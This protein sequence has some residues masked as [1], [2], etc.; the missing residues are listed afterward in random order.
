[1]RLLTYDDA[2]AISF[3]KDLLESELA[4]YP[5]AILSH[6]WGPAEEE[7]TYNDVL[8]GIGTSKPGSGSA[9]IRFCVQQTRRDGLQYFWVDTYCIDKTNHTELSEAL[10]SMFR[11]YANAQRCYVCLSDVT[12]D[13]WE[14]HLRASKWFRRGWTLQ[15]LIAPSTLEFFSKEGQTIGTKAFLIDQIN[16]ITRIP[17]AALQGKALTDFTVHERRQWQEGRETLKPEDLVYSLLGL[18]DISMPVLYGEGKVKA[19]ERLETAL[20]EAQKGKQYTD[21]SLVFSLAEAAIETQRFVARNS[22]LLEI[23]THLSSDGSRRTVVLHGLGGIGKTQL[24]MA[25]AKRHKDD[26][27]AILWLNAKSIDSIKSS[28]G[29][30]AKQILREHPGATP[31]AGLDLQQDLDGVV[32]A[33]KAWL[34]TP[35]NA[36]WLLICDNYD[37]PKVP[38]NTDPNALELRH[39]LPEAYQGAVIVTT[40]SSEVKLGHCLRIKKLETLQDGL[41]ILEDASGR[42]EL[43]KDD[44]A[45]RLVL[46][47]DG[48]PLALATAGAYLNQSTMTCAQYLDFFDRSWARLQKM[49]P[50]LLTYEDRTLYS[51]WQISF[52]QI[53]RQDSTAANL[54]RWWAYFDNQDVWFELLNHTDNDNPQWMAE[55]VEDELAFHACMQVLCDHGLVE[56]DAQNQYGVE[57]TGYSVHAC[58]HSWMTAVL[59]S[60]KDGALARAALDCIA[61]HVPDLHAPQ[62]SLVHRRLLNHAN[63]CL[64]YLDVADSGLESAWAW[65]TLGLLYTRLGKLTSVEKLFTR[66]LKAYEQAHGPDHASTLGAVNNLGVMYKNQGKLEEAEAMYRRALKGY[67]NAPVADPLTTLDTLH[68]LAGLYVMLGKLADAETLY[69]RALKGCEE[70][71]GAEAPSTLDTVNNLGMLYN[72]HGEFD[73]AEMYVRALRGREKALGADHTSTLLI[74]NNLAIVYANEGRVAEAEEMYVRALQGQEKALGADHLTTLNTVHNLAILYKYQGR[75]TEAEELYQRALSGYEKALGADHTAALRA[76]TNLGL[77]LMAQGRR[78]DAEEQYLRAMAGYDHMPPQMQIYVDEL[79]RLLSDAPDNAAMGEHL[80]PVDAL[81]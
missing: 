45:V 55:L 42:R 62:W 15:E 12:L 58:V 77:L 63:R 17:I 72:D 46:K 50:G 65:N 75:L 38:G 13:N 3:T 25:Y 60:Q 2:G 41:E 16:E 4:S 31:L 33:V 5:Y 27:S 49:S 29:K 69:L 21:F 74:V 48:L 28:F 39:Y 36:R 37:N 23:R 14:R 59:N 20:N 76:V 26:Y 30:M 7:V 8:T 19:A 40:R 22:E 68:N 35:M 57:S 81:K 61:S 71:L 53:E 47:L 73:K 51:T 11:W 56:A 66:E 80:L 9:K 78:E 52:D 70:T 54:L 24:A 32:D 43:A 44:D 1:M 10:I 64:D 79:G 34:S 6:R 18:L 67:E